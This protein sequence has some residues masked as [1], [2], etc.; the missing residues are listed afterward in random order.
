M[1][2]GILISAVAGVSPSHVQ[3]R[4]DTLFAHWQAFHMQH[5]LCLTIPC[6]TNEQVNLDCEKI[7]FYSVEVL[8][9]HLIRTHLEYVKEEIGVIGKKKQKPMVMENMIMPQ[10]QNWLSPSPEGG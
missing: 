1:G 10:L 3:L 5:G 4:D 7:C 6:I 2:Y 9:Q 8:Y